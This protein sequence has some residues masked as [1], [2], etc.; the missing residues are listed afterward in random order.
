MG[1]PAAL[2][3]IGERLHHRVLADQLVEALRPVFAGK[4]AIG[5]GA[6]CGSSG[7]SSPGR[8]IRR[9]LQRAGLHRLFTRRAGHERQGR[10]PPECMFSP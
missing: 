9:A 6:A 3:R 4:H 5:R 7:R 10:G 8:A 2:D 1:D